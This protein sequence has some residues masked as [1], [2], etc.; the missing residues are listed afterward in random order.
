MPDIHPFMHTFTHR[1]R[2]QSCKA[3]ASTSGAVRVMCL[4]QGQL[5]TRQTIET[6]R[7]PAD[8]LY[9]L[10][11]CRSSRSS[12]PCA[13]SY[14]SL[15]LSFSTPKGSPC[16]STT[17]DGTTE[18][19]TELKADAARLPPHDCSVTQTRARIL[20]FELECELEPE[21]ISFTLLK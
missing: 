10:S 6:L 19:I 2:S 7:L 20:L 13:Q 12:A 5:D 9:L 16:P 3:T 17:S 21:F 14:T 4:A 8:P 1:R 15:P 18:Y 11:Y